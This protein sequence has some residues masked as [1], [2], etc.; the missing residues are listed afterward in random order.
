VLPIVA[1]KR[2]GEREEKQT[3]RNEKKKRTKGKLF[4]AG[5]RIDQLFGLRVWMLLLQQQQQTGEREREIK[6]W[7]Q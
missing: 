7:T 5:W 2:S 1:C 6:E 3:D 4:S